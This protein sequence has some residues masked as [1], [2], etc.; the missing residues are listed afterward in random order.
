MS[1]IRIKSLSKEEL[2]EIKIQYALGISLN[3]YC[4]LTGHPC[5]EKLECFKRYGFKCSGLVIKSG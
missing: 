3:F 5:S 4:M 1:W 2:K